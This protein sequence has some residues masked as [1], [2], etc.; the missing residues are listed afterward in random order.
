MKEERV[1]TEMVFNSVTFQ[2]FPAYKDDREEITWSLMDAVVADHYA[3]RFTSQGEEA[4]TVD[5]EQIRPERN[6]IL[7]KVRKEL[8]LEAGS[9]PTAEEAREAERNL[10]HQLHE[11]GFWSSEQAVIHE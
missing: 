4:V 8:G 3:E 9:F 7:A 1:K 2:N 5:W 11:A 10:L 6:R